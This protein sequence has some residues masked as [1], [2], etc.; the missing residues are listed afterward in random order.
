[1]LNVDTC[2]KRFKQQ[3]VEIKSSQHRFWE[4]VSELQEFVDYKL[5]NPY[6]KEREEVRQELLE[7]SYQNNLKKAK[8][9][10]LK[11]K[12]KDSSVGLEKNKNIFNGYIDLDSG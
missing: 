10:K 2:R 4:Y 7:K 3:T 5:L 1:M 12:V 8:L 6:E 9:L 11:R